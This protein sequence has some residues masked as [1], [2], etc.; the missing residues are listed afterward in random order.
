MGR[1]DVTSIKTTSTSYRVT[2]MHTRSCPICGG[3]VELFMITTRYK[4]REIR[5]CQK[6]LWYRYSAR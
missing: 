1:G 2:D 4:D 5:Q 6:C 3:I